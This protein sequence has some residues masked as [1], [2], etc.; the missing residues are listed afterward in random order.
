MFWF[1]VGLIAQFFLGSIFKPK[2]QDN[3]KGAGIQD[4][5]V[6]TATEDRSIP[7]FW[8]TVKL[9]A[10]NLVWYGDL[11]SYS[12]KKKQKSGLFGSTS[13]TIAFD[14]CLGMNFAFC[15]GQVDEIQQIIFD[16]N[17]VAW[18][19]N[20][21]SGDF[22]V[23]SL[24][25]FGGSAVSDIEKNG[26]GGVFAKCTFYPGSPSQSANPYLESIL[27][28]CPAY[29][30]VSHLVWHGPSSKVTTVDAGK[31][32]VSGFIGTGTS[33]RPISFVLKRLPRSLSNS[34]YDINGN[35]N[36]AHV[37]YETLTNT[38]WGM[39]LDPSYI[40]TASFLVAAQTLYTEGFGY[41]TV[42]DREAAIGT[43]I[44]DAL[45]HA[46]GVV[47]PDPETGKIVFNLVR[48]VAQSVLDDPTQ[49]ITLNDDNGCEV[50]SLNENALDG[51]VNE[52]KVT[53]IDRANKFKEKPA[54][55]QNLASARQ[56]GSIN[57]TK[58]DYRGCTDPTNA[59]KLAYRD[60]R[61][62]TIPLKRLTLKCNREAHVLRPGKVFYFESGDY[63]ISKLLMRVARLRLGEYDNSQMEIE[64]VEDI[65]KFGTSVYGTPTSTGWVTPI[66]A[67]TLPTNYLVQE[68]P[69]YLNT[70]ETNRLQIF[71]TR[72]NI[73][74][75]NY[76]AYISTDGTTYTL[77]SAN[78]SFTPAATISGTLA[79]NTA[80]VYAGS[81]TIS[82]LDADN[83]FIVG[84]A[85][86]GSIRNGQNLFVIK[87]ANTEEIC[88]FET[89][90][91]NGDGTYTISNIWRGLFD[92]VPQAHPT[93]SKIW[94]YSYG[95]GY[96]VNIFTAGNTAYVKLQNNALNSASNLTSA[97]TI[98]PKRRSLKPIA[99]GYFRIDGSATTTTIADG[100][101]NVVLTWEHRDRTKMEQV[102]K[103][104]ENGTQEYKTT[105]S[106]K[107]YGAANAL[108]RTVTGLT[109]N[110]YTYTA[111][112]QNADNGGSTPNVLTFQLWAVREGLNSYQAQTRTVTR[113]GG[114]APTSPPAYSPSDSYVAIPDGDAGSI[115]GVNVGGTPTTTNQTLVY[116]SSTTQWEVSQVTLSGDVTGA[117]NANTVVK[118][119][120]R[121][122][123]SS[124]PSSGQALVWN[125]T[126]SQWEPG[127]ATGSANIDVL[128]DGSAIG[129]RSKLNFITGS[130]T[131]LTVTDNSGASRVDVTVAATTGSSL[132]VE[133]QD[134]TPSVSGVTKIKV[135]NGDLTNNGSG[136]VSIKTA[137][138][139]TPLTVKEVDGT[140]T[141]TTVTT[142]RFSNGT[143]TDDG[144]G[145][146]T[147]TTAGNSGT[148]VVKDIDGTPTV[149]ASTI[150][151]TNGTVSDQGGGTA[152]VSISSG[153]TTSTGSFSSAPSAGSTGNIYLP[154]DGFSIMR[155]NGSSYDHFGPI[156]KLTR[157]PLVSAF[158]WNNQGSATA[159]DSAS[160]I[161]LK[162]P[163]AAGDNIRSLEIAYPTA[164]FKLTI[165]YIPALYFVSFIQAGIS[166][167]DS[168]TGKL[169]TFMTVANTSTPRIQ[170]S[171]W[172]STTSFNSNYVS[173]IAVN[174]GGFIYLQ[175]ED[176]AT[177]RF[178]RF[179]LDG[180]NFLTFNSSTI[181]NTDFITPNKI[182]LYINT[183]SGSGYETGLTLLHWKQE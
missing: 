151:F 35:A 84:S 34:Y 136:V 153:N 115:N 49:T 172:N 167:R 98:V 128:K 43:V 142:L 177:N 21:S 137:A 152:R 66:G 55:A 72:T 124:A 93:G 109:S 65:F 138:D 113:T 14:Y 74:Q 116:N 13:Q 157:P 53:F 112:N 90:T 149:A 51:T 164:P 31:T 127:S 140:P 62:L 63:K 108:L 169:I 50:V 168:V 39:S 19:G 101:N 130:N 131:T 121:N 69:Y 6:P 94:F 32:Y 139:V 114:T 102:V 100:S 11:A 180:E 27:G 70:D 171:K 46:D 103:Q 122:L 148:V 36:I 48:E 86:T 126:S 88:A 23:N 160:G 125:N 58:I 146:V 181:G 104:F 182:G 87:S 16:D 132:I 71:S 135:G 162:C 166:L 91:N 3:A 8:G 10:P 52:V 105:Y 12:V 141:A 80:D 85:D 155:D 37:I 174:W 81:L 95:D 163:V 7:V 54:L 92:T 30:G 47:Y 22:T 41:S 29:R 110:T 179:S 33:L 96:P 79:Q 183:N 170:L 161:F 176:N 17:K 1:I 45:K 111:A 40:D 154:S 38:E 75:L 123:S 78:E 60:L 83:L 56:Q 73:S 67:S 145:Q 134:G 143:V 120:G 61:A 28:P 118:L 64:A 76:S 20:V 18:S 68:A 89:F 25:L 9:A 97:I 173:D 82:P 99:P 44:E 26:Q 4:F 107:I 158:T 15:H 133:E 150:E 165:G 42:W 129:T 144:G 77:A 147:I 106:L 57:S 59:S 2:V 117:A 156:F 178:F 24:K 159:T 5:N 119:Q 175:Y